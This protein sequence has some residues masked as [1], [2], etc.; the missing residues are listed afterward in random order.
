MSDILM[1]NIFFMITAISSVITT[2]L[3]V[4]VLIYVI[5]FIKK[6][7]TISGAVEEETVRIIGDVEEVRASVR[8]N[9]GVVKGVASAAVMRGLVEKIFNRK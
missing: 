1:T 5:K 2:I 8:K 3:L 4:V 6:L 7:H 9:I